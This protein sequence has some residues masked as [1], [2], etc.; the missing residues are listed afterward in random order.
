VLPRMFMA[1]KSVCVSSLEAGP[2]S[3]VEGG[4][5]F[6][7]GGGGGG[8]WR[9]DEIERFRRH[10]GEKRW[11]VEPRA[12]LGGADGAVYAAERSARRRSGD[13]ECI[14]AV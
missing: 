7:D 1:P 8:V 14:V 5:A 4:L 6:E 2:R 13:G 3:W 10:L 9:E 11:D 12:M